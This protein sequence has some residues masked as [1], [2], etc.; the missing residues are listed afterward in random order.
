MKNKL[1]FIVI[2]FFIANFAF[3]QKHK[4]SALE[5]YSRVKFKVT[6]LGDIVTGVNENYSLINVAEILKELKAN[7]KNRDRSGYLPITFKG[8]GSFTEY[9]MLSNGTPCNFIQDPNNA[10][11]L[12]FAFIYSPWGDPHPEFPG[13]RTQYWYSSNQGSNF[14]LITT[15]PD[16]R[17]GFP[18]ITLTSD[19]RA[20][21]SE[22]VG[23]PG[24]ENS[25]FFIDIVPG[26]GSFT[27]LTPTGLQHY[28]Y[29]RIISTSSV[30]L[31]NKFITVVSSNDLD[32]A[33]WLRGQ[34]FSVPGS[35]SSPQFINVK[36]PELY[37][38]ARGGDGRIGIA[39]I[40]NNLLQ[41]SEIGD[42]YFIESTDNG[43]SFD[44]PTKIFDANISPS[45]DS[46]GA[47]RGLSMV[48]QGNSPKVV[49][50]T[51]KQTTNG[52]Y[53]PGA[54][55]KIRFWSTSLPGSDPNRSKVI[56]D[57][58]NVSFHPYISKG[59]NNDLFASVC[60]PTIGTS[61]ES[62]GSYLFTVF[63]VPTN[64]CGG[65]VD[66]V[67]Y[68]NIWITCSDNNGT[69]WAF[70]QRINP[71]D[72][73]NLRDW[74]Y[75]SLSPIND[76][77]SNN[78]YYFNF[79]TLSDS[80]PGSYINHPANGRFF[81]EHYFGR[82]YI[83]I[84]PPE[85]PPPP[86]LISPPNGATNVLLNPTLIW[87]GGAS[88]CGLQVSLSQSFTSCIIDTIVGSSL[89]LV[90]NGILNINT[91]YYWRMHNSVGFT[92]HWWSTP[93]S[94][95]TRSTGINTISSEIPKEY[96]LYQNYPNPFNP[97]TKIRFD[98][99][100]KV[101]RETSNVKLVVYDILG[102]EVIT[103]VN[104]NLQPGAYEVPF[105][106]SSLSG[107]QISSGVYFYKIETSSFVSVKK[108][109]LIK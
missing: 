34:S 83:W 99:P 69:N 26:L 33:F 67:S 10:N 46:L 51:V 81:A 91:T 56:A 39:Y 31:Y 16:T 44:S 24:N 38:L 47:F 17:S 32:S 15:V 101:K 57:T 109:V 1:I 92:Y 27:E 86:V 107:N 103:L 8:T 58:S 21:L 30:S 70:P 59:A 29:P 104:E 106:S 3:A 7:Q 88:S 74:T 66:T 2:I 48:Y 52:Y 71:V 45:G 25:H 11:R 94:F 93:W 84:E 12:H 22:N 65:T 82:G 79:I 96:K 95:T 89:Y 73:N 54:P 35:F 14:N 49:F 5:K 23:S 77:S 60:R 37:C 40:A 9:D 19:G 68:M 18:N 75:P 6:T 87:S 63:M 4:E 108:L 90:Q 72:T 64:K 28:L 80:I 76:V 43:T 78:S 36:P 42:V 62:N 20:L 50:E 102:K 13:R 53:F 98:I 41:S 85:P 100:S 55:A 105:S 61:K 97:I